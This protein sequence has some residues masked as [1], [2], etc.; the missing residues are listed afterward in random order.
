[1]VGWRGLRAVNIQTT[2]KSRRGYIDFDTSGLILEEANGK[3]WRLLVAQPLL[4]GEEVAVTGMESRSST[5]VV[6]GVVR[7]TSDGSSD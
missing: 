5:L 1:V 2:V 3:R 7:H 4:I 6:R